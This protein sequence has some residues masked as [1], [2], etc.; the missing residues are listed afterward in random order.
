MSLY[1]IVSPLITA[2]N[3]ARQAF[4]NWIGA[5][6]QQ[7]TIDERRSLY[8]YLWNCYANT[9]YDRIHF[10]GSLD[11]VNET[12]GDAAAGDLA[13]IFNPVERIVE[14]HV[15]NVFNG[16]FGDE[17][18]VAPTISSL[19]TK[20]NVNQAILDPLEKIIEWSNLNIEKQSLVRWGGIFGSV[21]IRIVARVGND[22]PNDRIED[23]RVYL[24][25][26]HAGSVLEQMQDTR[27]NVSQVVTEHTRRDGT[28]D[29]MN[30]SRGV[31]TFRVRTLMTKQEFATFRRREGA[32]GWAGGEDF[33]PYDEINDKVNGKFARY[34]NALGVCPFVI[35]HHRKI[36][37]LWGA[38]AFFGQMRKIDILNALVAHINRQIF[39]HVNATYL[40]S[41]KGR[42]P[43]ELDFTGGS[44][45]YHRKRADDTTKLDMQPL[46]TN[47]SL[48]DAISQAKF[49]L[50]EL[51]DSMPELKATDGD[52]LSNQSGETVANLRLPA[53]QMILSS[54]ALYEDALI[55][56][57]QIALSYGVMLGI[58]HRPFK[59]MPTREG[60][61]Q[62]FRNGDFDFR[63]NNRAAL[64]IT[65]R[66]RLERAALEADLSDAE[67]ERRIN[68]QALKE[69]PP[70]SNERVTE[71]GDGEMIA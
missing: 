42:P 63:F 14:T 26:E 41:G 5:D 23:R 30:L 71:I 59:V 64:P 8:E 28:L 10:K 57:M 50:G 27:G 52:Y 65:E 24:Q 35:A 12:L 15:N 19:V 20:R 9:C 48:S 29:P 25:I 51:R 44:F 53:E 33:V 2:A 54:R 46:V 21:G 45:L 47:L 4:G 67:N 3:L 36:G 7:T 69:L 22:Y 1:R 32:Y 38:W 58:W 70:A 61:E 34:K 62:L 66:E 13:G 17:I 31:D 37:G 55:R 49:I 68:G 43:K 60:A 11:Y 16:S 40:I 39:R 56:A 18:Q 6:E